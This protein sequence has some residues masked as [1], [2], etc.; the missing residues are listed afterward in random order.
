MPEDTLQQ[1][2]LTVT[3]PAPMHSPR[4]RGMQALRGPHARGTLGDNIR[5][6]VSREERKLIED[7]CVRLGMSKAEFMRWCAVHVAEALHE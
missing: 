3:I 2:P 5:T 6:R 4:A 7:V 1:T